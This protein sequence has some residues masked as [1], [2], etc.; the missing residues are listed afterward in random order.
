MEKQ[1]LFEAEGISFSLRRLVEKDL[2]RCAEVIRESFIGVAEEFG[3]TPENC[4]AN[5][6]FMPD[7]QLKGKF[8]EG[9]PMFLALAGDAFA[10][11]FML[12]EDWFVEGAQML[13]KLAVLPAFRHH[14]L[15]KALLEAAAEQARVLGAKKLTI[16][17][18]EENT[19]LKNWYLANG[20][21]H[22]GTK[23]FNHLPFT[24]GYM[25]KIV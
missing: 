23:R 13:K 18:I 25:E 3:L 19:R 20:F 7:G 5:T 2:S 15:G 22:T 24:V 4:P 17:I 10:G 16:G 11:F 1:F 14:G 21:I 12:E 8:A 6:A 9:L